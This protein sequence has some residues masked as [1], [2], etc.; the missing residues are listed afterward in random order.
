MSRRFVRLVL[1][2]EDRQHEIFVRRYLKGIGHKRPPRVMR[3]PPAEGDARQYVLKR[4]PVEVRACR[5]K[6]SYQTVGLV[7]VIDA[8]RGLVENR[9]TQLSD[10]LKKH[11]LT[12][13]MDAEP[14]AI[15]VPKRNIETWIRYLLG[16]KVD[17]RTAYPKLRKRQSDCQPAVARLLTFRKENWELPGDCPPSLKRGC[18]EV[19]RIE[20]R[21]DPTR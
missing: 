19:R 21:S 11:G 16:K 6:G 7:T 13:R 1:L 15:W 8:D 14:I 20:D 3:P 17:E 5:S 2:C 12:K 18:R 10:Q 9:F 4:F